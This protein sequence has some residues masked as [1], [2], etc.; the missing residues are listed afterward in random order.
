MKHQKAV[1][2]GCSL[3]FI[4]VNSL[5]IAKEFMYIPLLSAAAV[6]AYLLIFRVDWAMY[7]MALSTPF[8]VVLE[9]EK[10]QLGISLP[11]EILMISLTLLFF[12]RIFYD[13]SIR[14]ELL[15]HPVTI[16]VLLYLAWMLLCCITSEFPMVSF[17][18][19]AA[20]I[21]F[22]TS[23]YFMVIHLIDKDID[24]FIKYFNCYAIS[25]A[26]VVIITTIK[27]AAIGF[28]EHAAH[29]V[30]E[31][32]YNDHTAYGAI[33][34]LFIPITTGFLFLKQTTKAQRIFYIIVLLI[35]LMGFYF[36]YSRAAWLSLMGAIGVWV[37]VKLHI[38]F[39]WVVA[40]VAVVGGLLFA[41]ADDILYSMSRNS[42][43]S[44]TKS[45]ADHLQSISNISTDASNVERLNRWNSAFR[46]IDERPLMG[47]GPGCYQFCYAPFQDYRYHT[48]IS[49]DFGDGGNAHSEFIG[50][51]AE[52][53]F[54]GLLTVVSMMILVLYY[55]IITA[56]KAKSLKVRRLSLAATLSLITYYIHGTMNNFLDTD[57]L[58][59]PFWGLFAL[60]VVLNTLYVN[61]TDEA[62][63]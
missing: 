56:V 11:A 7:L 63:K 23:S 13:L 55:G 1:V 9:N 61:Q 40:G 3:L 19:L 6:L 53:G 33:L 45:L 12:C 26:V 15:K 14:K 5:A 16:A 37:L 50:P 25:L 18:F 54:I 29:W 32:F 27:Y 41:F 47:W 4:L 28:G 24:N 42:Q 51:T 20:K 49:T 22:I 48:I 44:S 36:S 31:P 57:K 62:E 34:A 59:L 39:K 60:I 46:M 17:K 35:F 10:I 52:T 43:D 30:M 58:S 38:K 8:S 2:I 21:W